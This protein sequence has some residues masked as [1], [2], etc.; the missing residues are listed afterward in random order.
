VYMLVLYQRVMFGKLDNPANRKL[1][2]MNLREM[3]VM[4]PLI[5]AIFWI[6][7]QPQPLLSRMSESVR[8][9]V[10]LSTGRGA[11]RA[12]LEVPPAVTRAAVDINLSQTE[13]DE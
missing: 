5:I 7:L 11:I 6:G 3:V 9:A 10:A 4:A 1:K 13:D 2:D 12:E 8:S